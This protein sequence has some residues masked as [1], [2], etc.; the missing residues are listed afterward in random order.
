MSL[1][2]KKFIFENNNNKQLIIIKKIKNP[3]KKTIKTTKKIHSK[4][5]KKNPKKERKPKKHKIQKKKNF[6]TLTTFCI[7]FQINLF[8]IKPINNRI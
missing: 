6:I 3:Q 7:I 8:F 5:P 2:L 1:F 4:K